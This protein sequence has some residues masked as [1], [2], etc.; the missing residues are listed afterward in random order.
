MKNDTIIF[1]VG[2]EHYPILGLGR[3]EIRSR[4]S[5]SYKEFQKSRFSVNTTDR[6]DA[7]CVFYDKNNI[8]EAIEFFSKYALCLEEHTLM[9]VGRK[10]IKKI[11]LN[12]DA[13]IEEDDYGIISQKLSI[14]ISCPNGKV[15][16]VLIGVPGYYDE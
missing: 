9:Q 13:D 12:L 14:G 16:T 15:E 2:T 5:K 10:E 8:C 6:Y 7:F 3:A 1:E 11:L 4:I